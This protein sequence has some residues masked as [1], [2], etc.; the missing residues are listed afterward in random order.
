[1]S[2]ARFFAGIVSV[3]TMVGGV[4]GQATS[5][6]SGQDYP[7]K[8]IRIVTTNVGGSNDFVARVV[9]QGLAE[10]L[11]QQVVVDNR[12]AGPIPG[13]V[14]ARATPDAYTLMM[15]T[16]STWVGPLLQKDLYNPL[17]DFSP[18]VLVSKVPNLLVV[19]PS[20][21]AKSAKELIALAKAKPGE[22]N[23]ASG[24]SGG[25]SH[26]AV[27][28]FKSMAGVNI[29]RVA[30]KGGSA[31][32]PDLL[33]GRVQMTIDDVPTLMPN[34]KQGKLVALG[35]TTLQPSPLYPELI[36]VAATGLPG[37]ESAGMQGIFAPAK[38]PPELIRRVNQ[39]VVRYLKTPEARAKL[40]ALGYET[41]GSSPE[42]FAAILKVETER[43]GKLIAD[44][45][46]RVE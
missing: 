41:I 40:S 7:N 29:Q 38:T 27:E 18:V 13:Q 45:G 26:L 31:A 21:Q 3:L 44:I 43:M 11:R 32:L 36:T 42:E 19:H 12:P 10:S 24:P 34:I 5:T 25:G 1:M 46:L 30:Y 4:F 20:V 2:V 8:P 17:S 23:Y 22:L 35:I 16:S 39:E 15:G 9:A 6:G 28:L 14:A 33:A 37:Y